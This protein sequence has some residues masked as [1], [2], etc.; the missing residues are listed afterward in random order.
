MFNKEKNDNIPVLDIYKNDCI[1]KIIAIGNAINSADKLK[2]LKAISKEPMNLSELSLILKMPVSSVFYNVNQ[3]SKAGLITL[4]YQPGL[5]GKTKVCSKALLGVTI[6][7]SDNVEG[8]N[9]S[10]NIIQRYEMP[11]GA[12]T[13]YQ[14][15]A[16]CGMA[17]NTSIIKSVSNN[18][19]SF[20]SPDR[21]TAELLWFNTGFVC[22]SFPGLDNTSD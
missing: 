1:E 19:S 2:I 4:T 18:P 11:V 13:D 21:L 10:H 12:F 9:D 20:F 22:Y 8:K 14:I 15:T 5:K 16:P 17:N 7:F 6:N 3:L